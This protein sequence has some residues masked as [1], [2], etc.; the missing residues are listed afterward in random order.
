MFNH[1]KL[2]QWL[3][4]ASVLLTMPTVFVSCTSSSD[5]EPVVPKKSYVNE[6]WYIYLDSAQVREQRGLAN[7][8]KYAAYTYRLERADTAILLPE[9]LRTCNDAFKESY[10]SKMLEADTSF[11]PSR[12]GMDK[13]CLS[14]STSTSYKQ[15]DALAD[16]LKSKAGNK[17]IYILNLRNE[18]NLYVNGNLL[19]YY[20]FNN[21]A[22]IGRT[23]EEV[24]A[25]EATLCSQL[26]E[27]RIPTGAISEKTKYIIKDTTWI[28]VTEVLTEEQA[29][30][31]MAA[32]KG[33]NMECYRISAL[34][35]C[36]P[37][38][39]V[40][41][42]FLVFYRSLPQDAWV[43]MHCYAGRGRTTLF[44]AFFDMLRNPTVSEKDIVYRQLLIGGVNLYYSYHEGD[45][46][47][48]VPLFNEI[49]EMVSLMKLYVNENAATG[50]SK[51]W[52]EW[53]STKK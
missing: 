46:A 14:G 12:E 24:I 18:C 5:D 33:Y 19:N 48:R 28:D 2:A 41:D 23:K 44:M 50:Y 49:S 35:H 29:V 9:N 52:S 11:T 37:V 22:N 20:G 1:K 34:D 45:K 47:W 53:K 32:S 30:A 39:M 10:R 16:W 42:D 7:A 8:S 36:F 25:R 40:I 31:K 43:H 15:L 51:S 26:P 4:L 27:K 6:P 38:D 13:L 17:K 3:M 21:W